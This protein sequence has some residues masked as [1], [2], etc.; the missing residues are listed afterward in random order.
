[1]GEKPVDEWL[2]AESPEAWRET[3]RNGYA[4]AHVL[5]ALLESGALEALQRAGDAGRTAAELA[6]ECS[7]DELILD[8]VLTYLALSDVVLEKKGDRFRLAEKGAYIFEKKMQHVLYNNV[9]SYAVCLTELLPALR[10][11]KKY[12]RDFLRNGEYLA[13]GT[14]N[15]TQESHPGIVSA[16]EKYRPRVLGDLGCGS[17]HLS[18]KLCNAN[19]ALSSV[20]IDVSGGALEAAR[21]TVDAAG[22]SDR[23]NLVHGDVGDPDAW[24]EA[25]KD[26]DL[27][28]TVA[29]LH[30][31]LRDG[32][33]GVVRVLERMRALFPGKIFVIV[34]F[35]RRPDEEF[36]SIPLD[37]RYRWLFYQY[38]MHPLS[39]QGLISQERWLALF[40]ELGMEVLSVESFNLDVYVTRL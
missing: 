19:P 32:E 20:A 40:K 21:R 1:M 27:F 9:G 26:V 14:R 3:I 7:L 28:V 25:A 2:N 18:V 23:I 38:L 11:E 13:I 31:F 8:N 24:A 5:F 39:N 6:G 4:R 17:A 10:G 30:E 37:F 36:A 12:G 35:N 33:A 34:E 16:V 22:L 29:V 15:V